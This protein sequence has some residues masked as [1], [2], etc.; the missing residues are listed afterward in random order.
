[1]SLVTRQ[2]AIALSSRE[3]HQLFR[4]FDSEPD[5]KSGRT[6]ERL[7]A[8]R[9][10]RN[11]HCQ[12]IPRRSCSARGECIQSYSRLERVNPVHPVERQS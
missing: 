1:M 4:F 2:R 10:N 11:D 8:L 3:S 7:H 6:D 9:V 5:S 12:G